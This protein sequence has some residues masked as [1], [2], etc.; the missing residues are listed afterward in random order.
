MP[1]RTRT[2]TPDLWVDKPIL[3]PCPTLRSNEMVFIQFALS[4][5]EKNQERQE[6]NN[7]KPVFD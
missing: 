4:I 7:T 5:S 1:A 3:I 2:H 6:A